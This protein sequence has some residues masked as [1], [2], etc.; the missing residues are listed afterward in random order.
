MPGVGGRGRKW[1]VQE[2]AD[3]V[4]LRGEGLGWNAIATRIP[5]TSAQ[6]CAKMHSAIAN[7]E[8]PR[9][10]RWFGLRCADETLADRDARR[11]ESLARTDITANFFG[12]PLPGRSALD[13][14]R[15][16]EP[17]T[18]DRRTCQLAPK[19]TLYWGKLGEVR[20]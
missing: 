3:L 9:E 4:R 8:K 19:P 10:G 2:K 5:G 12:D 18:V 6:M 11:A 7:A 14:A 1:T 16:A 20:A 17:A 15:E 13:R